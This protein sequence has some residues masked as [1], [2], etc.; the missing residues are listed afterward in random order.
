MQDCIF[1]HQWNVLYLF[2]FW[3]RRLE[4]SVIVHF[5]VWLVTGYCENYCF[6]CFSSYLFRKERKLLLWFFWLMFGIQYYL[7]DDINER[8]FF[9][10]SVVGFWILKTILETLLFLFQTFALK[11]SLQKWLRRCNLFLSAFFDIG[12]CIEASARC[13]TFEWKTR[14]RIVGGGF[15]CQ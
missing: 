1:G 11:V 10:N 14:Y 12:L 4:D 7:F 2:F 9:E 5:F 15:L 3:N 13:F 8:C 6:S